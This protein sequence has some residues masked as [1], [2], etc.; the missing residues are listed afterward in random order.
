MASKN[1]HGSLGRTDLHWY[2]PNDLVLVE[3]PNHPLYDERVN[4]PP[5]EGTVL[6]I[7]KYGVLEPVLARVNGQTDEGKTIV[8]VMDG[9]Q[10]TRCARIANE[11]L[12]KDGREPH[13]VPVILKKPTNGDAMGI[14]IVANEVRQQDGP[15]VRARKLH[16]YMEHGHDMEDV[17]ATFGIKSQTTIKNLLGLLDLDEKVQEE[18]DKGRVSMSIAKKLTVFPREQQWTE[19]AKIY[20]AGSVAAARAL[21][22][23]N[24]PTE[25]APADPATNGKEPWSVS[26]ETT[27]EVQA[28]LG[29]PEFPAD[30][31]ETIDEKAPTPL[32]AHTAKANPTTPK[33][34]AK[35]AQK[36]ALQA[37]MGKRGTK[38]RERSVKTVAQMKEARAALEG[39]RSDTAAAFD[40]CLAWVLGMEDALEGYGPIANRLKGI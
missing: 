39:S 32:K 21:E 4:L 7:T 10:R 27:A 17:M 35:A 18:V 8:E 37:Q 9:R 25:P 15:L 33:K 30:E 29:K 12:L 13:R 34:A 2:D 24:T 26:D 38:L 14:M 19:L 36:A 3:D 23:R 20:E 6:S 40:A 22:A 11:R 5:H 1:T 16:R 31:P 28:M